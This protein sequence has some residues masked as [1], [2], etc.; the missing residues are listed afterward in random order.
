MATASLSAAV[1]PTPVGRGSWAGGAIMCGLHEAGSD[2]V[3]YEL[4]LLDEVHRHDAG[5]VVPQHDETIGVGRWVGG[6]LSFVE[7]C[8]AWRIWFIRE[9]R[10]VKGR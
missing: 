6:S 3:S 10:C 5:L 4:G 9:P 2:A 8:G 1:F 7:Q